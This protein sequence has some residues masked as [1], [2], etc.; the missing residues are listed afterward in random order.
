M[1]QNSGSF[2]PQWTNFDDRDVKADAE[3][4]LEA[5]KDKN[6]S[7]G[8]LIY[9][10]EGAGK[11]RTVTFGGATTRLDLLI[12]KLREQIPN[13]PS[14]TLIDGEKRA[15]LLTALNV[16]QKLEND[17]SA[18]SRFHNI[19]NM[20]RTEQLTTMNNEVTILR[21][22]EEIDTDFNQENMKTGHPIDVN[23]N[24]PLFKNSR[25]IKESKSGSDIREIRTP[26]SLVEENGKEITYNVD[27]K[28]LK[29]VPPK[30]PIQYFVR[31][32]DGADG[33]DYKKI[34][35]AFNPTEN[36]VLSNALLRAFG[37]RIST[38]DNTSL[39][40]NLNEVIKKASKIIES[41][42]EAA[43]INADRKFIEDKCNLVRGYGTKVETIDEKFLSSPLIS[44]LPLGAGMGRAHNV[45]LFSP[46][47]QVN[48][49][50]SLRELEIFVLRNNTT[51]EIKFLIKENF[52]RE[53]RNKII[54]VV[55]NI[56]KSPAQAQT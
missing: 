26:V 20:S 33:N 22:T 43:K 35:A 14:G 50:G 49:D 51:S 32:A 25:I 53:T 36:K 10:T 54:E 17:A 6:N 16:L 5:M 52:D 28:I 46:K 8:F 38:I 55:G 23:T 30:G 44:N 21:I 24:N 31:L 45:D 9:N 12:D 39:S 41:K 7:S 15:G 4:I 29:F 3:I 18:H 1:I 48:V 27:F 34:T 19:F 42:A 40:I 11:S 56:L 37:E 13:N 2:P 47:V